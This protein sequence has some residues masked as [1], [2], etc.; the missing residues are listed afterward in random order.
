MQVTIFRDEQTEDAYRCILQEH[1][2]K[3]V[4]IRLFSSETI[5]LNSLLSGQCGYSA[6]ICTSQKSCESLKL[7]I[8]NHAIHSSWLKAVVY[9][10]GPATAKSLRALGFGTLG[11]SCGSSKALGD[12]IDTNHNKNDGGLLFLCGDKAPSFPGKCNAY[13]TTIQSYITV[14]LEFKFDPS[15]TQFCVFF[16]PSGVEL[17]FSQ[18]EPAMFTDVCCIAIGPSTFETLDKHRIIKKIMADEPTPTGV[19]RAILIHCDL[20]KAI[21]C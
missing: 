17:V 5:N 12:F 9:C 11:E 8:D 3:T 19:F 13:T 2:F 10:V 20:L 7:A 14:P 4:F 6:L 15:S 16:S 18:V 21:P 1:R